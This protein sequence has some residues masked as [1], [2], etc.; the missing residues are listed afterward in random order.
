MQEQLFDEFPVQILHRLCIAAVNM[1][2][3]CDAILTGKNEKP[4]IRKKLH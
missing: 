4:D 1:K 2:A 3:E